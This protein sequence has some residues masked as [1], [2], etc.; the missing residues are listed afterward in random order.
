MRNFSLTFLTSIFCMAMVLM[1][2]YHASAQE[3]YA[4]ASFTGVPIEMSQAQTDAAHDQVATDEAQPAVQ[5]SGPVA[6]TPVVSVPA[7]I[8]FSTDNAP[9]GKK[10]LA[11]PASAEVI[12][13]FGVYVASDNAIFI[14]IAGWVAVLAM[15][16]LF[17]A[18]LF[19]SNGKVNIF[20]TK[21]A[22][23]LRSSKK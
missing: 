11:I 23:N 15:V 20:L 18:S 16:L 6:E 21:I 4:A 3:K 1:L 19:S 9:A 10:W 14:T 17:I 22:N 13:L 12:T 5:V 7:E 8:V 2:P